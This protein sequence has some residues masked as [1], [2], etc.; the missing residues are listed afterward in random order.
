MRSQAFKSHTNANPQG[1]EVQVNYWG[2]ILR[3]GEQGKSRKN[4]NSSQE[5]MGKARRL[6]VW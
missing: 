1:T 2:I 4:I 3:F 6:S 5:V